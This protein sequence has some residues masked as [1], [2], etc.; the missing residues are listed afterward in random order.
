MKS[1]VGNNNKCETGTFMLDMETKE[2]KLSSSRMERH[3][4]TATLGF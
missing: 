2:G 4:T 1:N 3:S